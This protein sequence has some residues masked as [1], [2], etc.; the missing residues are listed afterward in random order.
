MLE[1]PFR[2]ERQAKDQ[3]AKRIGGLDEAGRGPLAGP[4]VAAVCVFL[5][6]VPLKGLNDSKQVPEALREELFAQIKAH[7]SIEYGIGQASA[8]EVDRF[9]IVRASF[10]AMSRALAQLKTA[11]DLLLIDG[12]LSPSFGI[13]IVAIVKGDAQ[14]ASIA[15]ASILAKVTRDRLMK[16][17]HDEFPQYGFAEHK[18]YGVPV[19]LDALRK[20][21]PCSAH[22][23]T[24]AP[25]QAPAPSELTLGF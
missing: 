21:G 24:F 4:V 1:N 3:G 11:P 5:E 18:G 8:A 12:H 23:R 15:A 25:V 6:E 9:N 13:P 14:S 10:L 16:Q 19:H 7:P 22:R 2:F 20:F 17:L